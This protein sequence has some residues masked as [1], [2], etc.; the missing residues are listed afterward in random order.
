MGELPGGAGV[1][2]S[3]LGEARGAEAG[4]GGKV[5]GPAAGGERVRGR[6][7]RTG[8]LLP[9]VGAAQNRQRRGMGVSGEGLREVEVVEEH[10]PLEM[11]W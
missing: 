10:R 2:T 4:V 6:R 8:T 11:L 9:R 7:A 5:C 3:P 1:G